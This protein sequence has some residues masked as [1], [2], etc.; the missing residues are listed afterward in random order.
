[1]VCCAACST[2]TWASA[3][4]R[5][6]AEI[7]SRANTPSPC[8]DGRSSIFGVDQVRR[9]RK[10]A[11]QLSMG[12]RPVLDQ[13]L[14]HSAAQ[15]R[16]GVELAAQPWVALYELHELAA[17]QGQEDAWGQRADR[18]VARV[19]LE[20]RHLAEVVAVLKC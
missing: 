1:M 8:A 16:Y 15:L 2:N 17:L 5:S 7:A 14:R 6:P 9:R 18:R 20:Q 11:M 19:V 4:R 3:I 10:G 12:R 13:G